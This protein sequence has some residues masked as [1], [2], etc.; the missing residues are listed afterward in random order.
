MPLA[1]KIQP[2]ALERSAKIAPTIDEGGTS[3]DQSL[4]V[5]LGFYYL[6]LEADG[7]LVLFSVLGIKYQRPRWA[8]SRSG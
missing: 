4:G 6:T 8:T 1:A 7:A 5:P 2:L 3:K